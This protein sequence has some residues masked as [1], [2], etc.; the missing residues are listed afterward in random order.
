MSSDVKFL[1]ETVS[2]IQ[3]YIKRAMGFGEDDRVESTEICLPA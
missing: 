2:G 3:Q 1:N